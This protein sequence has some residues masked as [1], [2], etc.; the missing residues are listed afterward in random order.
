[1]RRSSADY[2]EVNIIEEE[3]LQKSPQLKNKSILHKL[4]CLSIKRS[5]QSKK[6][7]LESYKKTNARLTQL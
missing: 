6:R 1:V 7:I 5:S 2:L 3:G 4:H